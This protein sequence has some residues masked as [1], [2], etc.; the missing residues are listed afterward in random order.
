MDGKISGNH[1]CGRKVDLRR[2]VKIDG[3]SAS[4]DQYGLCEYAFCITGKCSCSV[5]LGTYT[6]LFWFYGLGAKQGKCGGTGFI[7]QAMFFVWSKAML[8]RRSCLY[9]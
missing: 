5:C 3:T 9:E 4:D 8:S 1:Y 2:G 6:Y 7:L